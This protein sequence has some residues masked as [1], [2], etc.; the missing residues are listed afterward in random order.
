M[1]EV[2]KV[3]VQRTIFDLA[4]MEEVTLA[5]EVD[6]TP[7]ESTQEALQRLEGNAGKFL[8]IINE[9]LRAETRRQAGSDPADWRTLTDEGEVNGPFSG[10]V[11]D[12]KAVNALVLTLAKTVFGYSKEMDKAS[13]RT[14][15]DSALS[16]IKNTEAIKEGLKKSAALT[17]VED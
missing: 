15:K 12:I 10:V 16:M 3:K 4:V 13:K 9:G 14:A 1:A 6:Y 2:V 11:A 17:P 7:V 8:E 5:K